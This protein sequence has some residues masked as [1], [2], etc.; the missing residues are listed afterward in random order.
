MSDFPHF[1]RA[2]IDLVITIF[3]KERTSCGIVASLW[4]EAAKR[5]V[6]C[7]SAF[8][9][10][11]VGAGAT[12]DGRNLLSIVMLDLLLVLG[13]A[14]RGTFAEVECQIGLKSESVFLL[15]EGFLRDLDE[16]Q[17]AIRACEALELAASEPVAVAIGAT[18]I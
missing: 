1:Q 10:A 14:A 15:S 7:N 11:V 2:I 12:D 16:M 3:A 4:P 9:K 18:R 5:R 13:T 8:R 17:R 6:G